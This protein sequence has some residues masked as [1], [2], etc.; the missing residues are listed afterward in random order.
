M[1]P[2]HRERATLMEKL[3]LCKLVKMPKVALSDK[4][5]FTAQ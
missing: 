1:L 3:L 4:Y 5:S 2:Y